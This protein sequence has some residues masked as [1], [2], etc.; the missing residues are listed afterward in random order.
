MRGSW[1]SKFNEASLTIF[2]FCSNRVIWG[3]YVKGTL[4][5]WVIG[6]VSG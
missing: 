5:T 2:W 4:W 3:A 6:I 1:D